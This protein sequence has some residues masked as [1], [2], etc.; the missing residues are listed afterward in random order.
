MSDQ[1]YEQDE[2]LRL[3]TLQFRVVL[4][5]GARLAAAITLPPK[6]AHPDLFADRDD[7]G[8]ALNLSIDYDSGQLH[9]LLDEAGPSFHYH[10]T[11]DPY[12]SPW[13]EDQTAILLEWAL[14]LVQEIGG[15][16]ELLDSIYEAAEWF[17]QGFTLYVPETDPTQLELIEVDIIGELLTLPWL[18]SGRVDHE[19]IDGDNHP[20]ALLW[21]MNNADPDVP[22]ARAWLDPQTGEPRTA[23]EPGVD[24]TAVAMSEDEVLQWLVGIYTNH[25]VAPTPEAQIMRAALER[26]GGIS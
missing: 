8:E 24:W 5:L 2:T 11:A 26:M 7:E 20:I 15:L 1:H 17:E 22:I 21:N 6:L 23:A 19:H 18:G 4:D 9:V 3:P 12:E 13:P 25:H 16:D 14:I 10:G